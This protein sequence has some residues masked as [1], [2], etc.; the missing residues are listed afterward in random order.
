MGEPVSPV[1]T[2]ASGH[3]AR[4]FLRK[5]ATVSSQELQK[6]ATVSS[7][8]RDRFFVDNFLAH[9]GVTVVIHKIKSPPGTTSGLRATVSAQLPC[10]S[11]VRR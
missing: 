6:S 7:Q 3:S 8:K 1:V 11:Y 4:P 10:G 9:R 5:S 2:C